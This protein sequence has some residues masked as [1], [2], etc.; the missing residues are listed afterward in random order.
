M[1]HAAR[2]VVDETTRHGHNE[3][4]AHASSSAKVGPDMRILATAPGLLSVARRRGP[5]AVSFSLRCHGLTDAS[6]VGGGMAAP[7]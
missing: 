1:A 2:L 3:Q 5:Q 7:T 4:R 6:S